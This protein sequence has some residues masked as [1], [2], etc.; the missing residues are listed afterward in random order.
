[1]QQFTRLGIV[2]VFLILII[3][4]PYNLAIL[5]TDNSH[6]SKNYFINYLGLSF[7]GFIGIIAFST[8]S[9]FLFVIFEILLNYIKTGKL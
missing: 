3:F 5:F 8:I 2:L 4:I 9:V 1:M 7:L 6:I